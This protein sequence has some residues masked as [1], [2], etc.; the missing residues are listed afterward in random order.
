MPVPAFIEGSGLAERPA[1]AGNVLENGRSGNYQI[2]KCFCIGLRQQLRRAFLLIGQPVLANEF[3]LA[4]QQPG[5]DVIIGITRFVVGRP[6]PDLKVENFV[7]RFIQQSVRI[8]R[9]G[10]ET[11]THSRSKLRTPIVCV[12]RGVALKYVHKLVL[13]RM[14]MS[15]G[16]GGSWSQICQVHAEVGEPEDIT[17]L[18]LEASLSA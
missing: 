8:P 3:P 2:R 4:V 18:T 11:R 17:K 5:L 16:R 13:L 7:L 12:Q 10:L 15:K 6:V 9:A 1:Q 14:C